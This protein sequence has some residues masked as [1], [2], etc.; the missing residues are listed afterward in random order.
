M[1]NGKVK[2]PSREEQPDISKLSLSEYE[3]EYKDKFDEDACTFQIV[4]H[5]NKKAA[6]SSNDDDWIRKDGPPSI[7]LD[8]SSEKEKETKERAPTPIARFK[9]QS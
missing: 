1:N 8:G 4:S 9:R 6:A 7:S 5:R 3:S 2:V